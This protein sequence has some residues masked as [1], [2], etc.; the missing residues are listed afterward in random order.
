M[1]KINWNNLN[2]YKDTFLYLFVIVFMLGFFLL[3]MSWMLKILMICLCAWAYFVSFKKKENNFLIIVLYFLLFY[4]CYSLFFYLGMPLWLPMMLV[5]ILT[6]L[7][8]YFFSS[9]SIVYAVLLT[10]IVLEI[11]LSLI[12][13]PTD[14]KGKSLILVG[15]IYLF[16][17]ISAQENHN[18]LE[19]K[20]IIPYVV[21]CLLIIILVVLTSQWYSL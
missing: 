7:I 11:F 2:R 13:W 18:K 21:I 14:P 1:I 6:A 16:Y 5:I 19:F 4:N 15:V 12:S 17:G 20:K 8:Y 9:D 3:E 10:L